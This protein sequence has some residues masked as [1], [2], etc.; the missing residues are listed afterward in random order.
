MLDKR[1]SPPA[2]DQ[3]GR[4]GRIA[5]TDQ[6]VFRADWTDG[7]N[8]LLGTYKGT[9]SLASNPDYVLAA[10][11]IVRLSGVNAYIT[12]ETQGPDQAAK[13]IAT[14]ADPKLYETAWTPGPR[15][16][17]LVPY[18]V[19]AAGGGLDKNGQLFTCIA[20]VHASEQDAKQNAD[21]LKQRIANARRVTGRYWSSEIPS[22]QTT[23]VGRVLEVKLPGAVIGARFLYQQDPLLL[24]R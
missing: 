12:N 18:T 7:I 17:L 23:V 4:G 6:Y 8:Q 2:F 9:H 21:L 22:V 24:H 1:L 15:E 11:S 16:P 10:K 3:L 13:A 14:S 20:L 19:V 5:V